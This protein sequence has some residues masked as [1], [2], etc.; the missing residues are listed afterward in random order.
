MVRQLEADVYWCLTKQLDGIQDNFTFAQ[1]G[2]QL[3]VHSLREL[4]AR[5]DPP[6]HA[7][8]QALNIEYLQFAL[9][10]MNCLLTREIPLACTIRLVLLSLSSLA[11][12]LLPSK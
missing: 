7:H 3:K 6:L 8:L 2:I 11:L 4:T 10:W 5:I 9:R 1:P 12:R